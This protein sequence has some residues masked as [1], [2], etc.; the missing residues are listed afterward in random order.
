MSD[1]ADWPDRIVAWQDMPLEVRRYL[2]RRLLD[3]A[4]E[5]HEG[6]A[7]LIRFLYAGQPREGL[8]MAQTYVMTAHEFWPYVVADTRSALKDRQ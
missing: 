5:I 7:G 4:L 1:S 8:S 2:T 3:R 6:P